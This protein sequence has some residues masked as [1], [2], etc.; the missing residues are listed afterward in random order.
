MGAAAA[1][2]TGGGTASALGGLAGAAS[3]ITP[4]AAPV[5]GAVNIGM[6]LVESSKQQDLAKAA[7]RA[8]EDAF[9]E[10]K[11]LQGQNFFKAL[12]VPMEAYNRAA[13]ETTAQQQQAVSALQEGDSRALVGGIGKVNAVAQEGEAETRDAL[14]ADLYQ[15]GAAQAQEQGNTA[16]KMAELYGAQGS[17]AQLAAANAENAALG[18]QGNAIQG[19]MDIITS[20]TGMI[21]EYSPTKVKDQLVP[22]GAAGQAAGMAQMGATAMKET[23]KFQQ[24]NA[25]KGPTGFGPQKYDPFAALR[26]LNK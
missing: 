20:L 25:P 24:M 16:D 9:K 11:R 8:A 26:F 6:S 7:N 21:P 14:A 10:Q 1:G 22:L 13:K 12:Q 23:N 4:W 2:S 18:Q 19:G 3:A 17:G 15:L 5:M